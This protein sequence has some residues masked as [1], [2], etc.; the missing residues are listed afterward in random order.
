MFLMIAAVGLFATVALVRFVGSASEAGH[1]L[2]P[3][4]LLGYPANLA[5]I[6]AG[7]LCWSATRSGL[8]RF[9]AAVS[10]LLMA[11]GWLLALSTGLLESNSP[12]IGKLVVIAAGLRWMSVGFFGWFLLT[13]DDGGV[14]FGRAG[15]GY[16]V[17]LLPIVFGVMLVFGGVT[18]DGALYTRLGP[19]GWPYLLAL[20]VLA[21]MVAV[22]IPRSE[23]KGTPT[24]AAPAALPRPA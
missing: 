2:S 16:K 14:G 10:A 4:A 5:F 12:L 1:I 8:A 7:G 20:I 13:W 23:P 18:R 15:G 3:L 17:T 24:T 22:R 19:T 21:I 11:A 9:W 6:V